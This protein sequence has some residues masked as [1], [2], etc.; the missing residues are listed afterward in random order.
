VDIQ[1]FDQVHRQH[2]YPFLSV[3]LNEINNFKQSVFQ[4]LCFEVEDEDSLV[5]EKMYNRLIDVVERSLK[6]LK[7]Q[8]GK[9]NFKWIKAVERNFKPIEDIYLKFLLT[10]EGKQ[11]HERGK[12]I[13][14]IHC[15]LI[16]FI[17][18]II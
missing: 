3:E 12:I 11:R 6:I 18:L 9:N 4:T 5:Y 8:Q 2:Q 16:E 14:K 13:H 7:D 1:F 10:K 17:I 15:F